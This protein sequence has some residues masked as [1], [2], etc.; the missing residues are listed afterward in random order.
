M[1]AEETKTKQ[2]YAV[3]TGDYVGQ[4]FIVCEI[5]EKGIGCLSVPAM[6][7]V[8]VPTDK[9]TIGR[10]SDIIEYV[11]ELSRDIFTVCAAQY[12]KNEDFNN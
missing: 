6:K 5:T 7:N 2:T 4:I 10:N 3:Q 12:K 1:E 11:E 9:W 8:L